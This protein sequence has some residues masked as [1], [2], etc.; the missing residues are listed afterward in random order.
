[1]GAGIAQLAAQAGARTLLH[2]PASEALERGLAGARARLE[3]GVEKGRLRPEALGTLEAAAGLAGLAEADLV[4]EA[5][6]EDLELKRRL[7][8]DVA[9]H[10]GPACVLATN[11]SSLSVTALAA[12]V[13]GPERVVGMHFFNPAPVMELVEVV[14]GERS[15]AAALATARAAGE[16]M[17]RRVIQ[18][19][20]GPGFL[21]NRC[22]RPFALEALRLVEQRLATPEQVDRI[23]RMAGG[24][25]MGPFE[26]M[27]LV[28]VDVG[29]AVSESFFRQGFGEPRWRPSPLA[30]RA[31]AAGRLG[32]KTGEGWYRYPDGPP[33]DSAPPAPG[34]GDGLVVVAGESE[35]A[36]ALA[37]AA[38]GA[39]WDVA[40][41]G[42][43]EGEVP[44]LILDCGATDADPPLQ[45]GPQLLLC[46][47]APLAA[48]DPGGA[49]AGFHLLAPLGALAEL[50]AGPATAPA[51]V[52]AAERFFATLGMVSE[53]VGDAPGLV[54]GRIVAQ[55]VNEACFAVGEG[56][57]APADV[58][59]GMV[60]GLNHPRGPLEWGDAIGPAE[61]LAVL[62]GLH[63]EYREERYRPA[64][65]L[66]RAVRGGL[67]LRELEG[68]ALRE[69]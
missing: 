27:D 17:G 46:D 37:E 48:M 53:R 4:I 14:A 43:A 44:A 39:G 13:P 51:T 8:R 25:R 65:A 26:L 57:G 3:R 68:G 30:A 21:V 35:V 66:L 64:P 7:F 15:S 33:A 52:A 9:E 55:L 42:E 45:G 16:A 49:S 18:A 20:D 47:A 19:A 59:A 60:L 2:D 61:V 1:M 63:E 12:R 36:L 32:R 62:A 6:P 11:T 38:A 31:V 24:F 28:G 56:V 58:D 54:L 5:A 29:F 22:N 41:P 69:S 23:C 34:G 67:A 10:V 50:T 40:E